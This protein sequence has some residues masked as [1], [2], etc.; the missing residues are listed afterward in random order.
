MK[1]SLV[2]RGRWGYWLVPFVIL[3][4]SLVFQACGDDDE[5]CGDT[6]I[7]ANE[8]ECEEY[9]VEFDCADFSYDA[10]TDVCVVSG[11]ACAFII[12][13]IDDF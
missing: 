13:D 10:E 7:F 12:D 4:F 6:E 11:C 8:T 9:A 5:S 1:T 3:A 2:K